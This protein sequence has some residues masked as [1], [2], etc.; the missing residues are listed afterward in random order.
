ME[1]IKLNPA[2][3][4]Y[5]WGGEKLKTSYN[6]VT[7]LSIVAETWELSSHKDGESIITNGKFKGKF[8]SEY[9]KEN[10]QT[11]G[12]NCT[13]FKDFPILIKFIDAKKALSIQVHPD[14]EYALK[15]ENS[16]G[17]T[18]MWYILEAEKDSFL[19]YG[20]NKNITK[21]E[22]AKSIKDNT[23]T[24]YLNKVF[25]KPGETFFIEP[26]TVHAIGEGIVI[27]EIQQNSNM[28]YRV[29]DYDRKDSNGNTRELHIDKA[30][31]V[32]ILTKSNP[33]KEYKLEKFEGYTKKQLATCNYF[34]TEFYNVV[35]NCNL[36]IDNTSFASLIIT[37]GSGEI[38]Y[39]NKSLTFIKGDSIFIPAGTGELIINGICEFILTTV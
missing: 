23:I 39:S 28:T 2:F 4:D 3:K 19:Y 17:K 30:L 37:V 36:N 22:Y 14:D 27:C 38:V 9:L 33:A 8:F 15:F 16:Y 7:D 6:K 34:N 32:S 1:V 21:E 18:E 12:T 29:Y 35:K 31:D 24:T 11:L 20:F 10:P 25:V 13:K 5:L 26:G